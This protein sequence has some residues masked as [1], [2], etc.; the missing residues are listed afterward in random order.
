MKVLFFCGFFHFVFT[1]LVFPRTPET[2]KSVPA[3]EKAE[4]PASPERYWVSALGG[5]L[6]SNVLLYSF[7]RYVGRYDFSQVTLKDLRG[8]FQKGWE[9]DTDVFATNQFAHPYHGSTYHAAARANGFGFYESVF[10]DFLG[11]ASWE[12]FAET[13]TPSF[14]DLISTT[15]GG[16]SLGEMFHRLYLEINFPLGGLISPLDAFNAAV[17]RRKLPKQSGRNIYGLS[18]YSGHEW[19]V[20][21][22]YNKDRSLTLKTWDAAAANLNCHVIYGNPFAQGNRRP[23]GHFEMVFG[24]SYG[25]APWYDMYI[26]SDGYLFSFSPGAGTQKNMSTGL[27]LNYDFFTSHNIDF[28]RHGLDWTVKYRRLFRNSALELKAHAGWTAFGAANLNFY[29]P[30]RQIEETHRDYGT[31]ANAKFFFSW[32]HPRWGN[33]SL[34][35]LFYGIFI[36]SRNR[37][38]SRGWDF[39]YLFRL[40]YEYPLGDRIAVGLNNV[41]Q[42]KNGYY[43]A[44][45]GTRKITN[46]ASIYGK[47]IIGPFGAYPNTH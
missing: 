11:S 10:F 45:P 40:S 39:C 14:N 12:I 1:A 29:D 18:V 41:Q 16:A 22:R 33:F 44:V 25:G 26:I 35:T 46:T 20:S 37:P 23:Y 47:F 7:N 42:S 6:F 3:P 9:W 13:T 38:E 31:G 17:T 19:N 5:G 30:D 15:L 2:E 24:G 43:T 8:K 21:R 36:I 32:S 4:P 27:S 34:D 28:F